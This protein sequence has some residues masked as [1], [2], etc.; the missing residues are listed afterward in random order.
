MA[1][2]PID[3]T[4]L[5]V[6]LVED[7]S[8]EMDMAR[9]AVGALG[10]SRITQAGGG[11]QAL[12]ALDTGFDCDLVISD[13][14]MPNFDGLDLLKAV[15]ERWFD[16]TFLMVTNNET[17]DH[18][19]AA[20]ACGVDGYLIKPYSLNQLREA[21]QLALIARSIGLGA[22]PEETPPDPELAAVA[23]SIRRA[24]AA[25]AESAGPTSAD[26]HDRAKTL[27][28]NL[29]AQLIEFTGSSDSMGPLGAHV[30]RLHMDCVDA[31]RLG[32]NQ[33]L[34]HETQNLIV[35]GLKLAVG[36]CGKQGS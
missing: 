21:V 9:T 23:A 3:L 35:D 18:I 6:L 32:G 2:F 5:N 30:I 4:S 19:R 10:M 36:L 20:R 17:L 13:W 11:A 16:V 1:N 34:A 14:N 22:P 8:L 33:L 7:D 15:R 25:A 24:L 28:T 27:G 31:L 29:S 12:A 26:D